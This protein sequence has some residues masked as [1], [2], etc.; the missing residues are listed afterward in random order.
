MT[1]FIQPMRLVKFSASNTED[2]NR[3]GREIWMKCIHKSSYEWERCYSTSLI[4]PYILYLQ[5]LL[6]LWDWIKIAIWIDHVWASK[7]LKAYKEGQKR[8]C[9]LRMRCIFDSK[10]TR[11]LTM[12]HIAWLLIVFFISIISI[13]TPVFHSD[14]IT[15]QSNCMHWAIAKQSESSI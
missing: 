10:T 11:M 9:I 14:S 13:F 15:I 8:C 5:Y 12:F 1:L 7:I 4:L 6:Y 3:I 2:N